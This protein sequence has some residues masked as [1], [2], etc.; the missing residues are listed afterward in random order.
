MHNSLA[1]LDWL[2]ISTVHAAMLIPLLLAV[3]CF[4]LFLAFSSKFVNT[5]TQQNSF[6][7]LLKYLMTPVSVVVVSLCLKR[8]ILCLG[9]LV[10]CMDATDTKPL[11]LR[12][13]VDN[14]H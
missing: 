6:H 2:C 3:I 8:F 10:T 5:A 13:V 4:S 11:I 9:A 1:S 7:V 12:V 14:V